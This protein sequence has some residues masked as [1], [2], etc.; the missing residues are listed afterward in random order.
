MAFYGFVL[1]RFFPA[2]RP[3]GFG[4]VVFCM[5]IMNALWWSVA[6]RRFARFIRPPGLSAGLRMF[7][8]LFVLALNLPILAMLALGRFPAWLN[9][10]PTWF[11]A[12]LV[13][14]QFGLVFLMPIIA[15]LRLSIL[16]AFALTRR[17]RGP[18]AGTEAPA[19]GVAP[20]NRRCLA[21][22][23]DPTR[24]ALLRTSVASVPI[25]AL[26]GLTIA[27]R[28]QESR[29]QVNRHELP[30]PWLPLR[31]RGLTITHISD[32]HL[33]RHF[34]PQRLP[35]LVDRANALDSDIVVITGDIVD[36]S[37]EFLPAALEA[38]ARLTHRHGLFACIGNHDEIDDRDAFLRTCRGRMPV[39]LNER[40]LLYI[41]GEHLTIAGLDWTRSDRATAH[42]EGH[43]EFA[44]AMLRGY[45]ESLEGPLIALAHHPHAWDALAP[46][47]VPLVLS[48][49]T[50][51]GQL[52]L[53]PPDTRPDAGAGPVL[54][55]YVRGFY[56]RPGST[57]FVN[58]G[59]G[60]WFPLRINA[61]A[62]I[63]Q[64]R[65]V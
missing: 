62:E 29:L 41:D 49:H 38:F 50:H 17:F 8:F 33:G 48:G 43:E 19:E 24:R 4:M 31:L 1:A 27:S 59:V 58:R 3:V 40:R 63:V 61:P 12:A 51:G 57:L 54:F 36:V 34:R 35:E 39:L 65:L 37:N 14:W 53:N 30:A 16:G 23:F 11:T 28:R 2:P 21:V 55:R 45:D 9:R 18:S 10:F 56:E 46:R 52:M 25:A 6:D 5:I 44:A 26:A 15:S 64:I 20:A 32:L 47:G 42:R 7:T 60:N 22:P 13:L